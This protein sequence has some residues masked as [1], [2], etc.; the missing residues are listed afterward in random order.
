MEIKNFE[1]VCI[2]YEKA[3][4]FKQTCE[5]V[6]DVLKESGR[7]MTATEIA[8]SIIIESPFDYSYNPSIQSINACIKKLRKL[9][10]VNRREE[11]TG[12]KITIDPAK[13]WLGYMK[14]QGMQEVFDKNGNSLGTQWVEQEIREPFEIKEKK[15][16]FSL[17]NA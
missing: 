13:S 2:S 1:R 12:K 9:K 16:L 7:E 3:N 8:K 14:K 11:F 10:L 5:R 17:K 15:V 4:T 6:C